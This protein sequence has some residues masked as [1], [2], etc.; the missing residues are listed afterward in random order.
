V[1]G[2]PDHW[3]ERFQQDQQVR[4]GLRV[5]AD[6]LE[7][8]EAERIAAI[9]AARRGGLSVRQ[10]AAA[11]RLSPARVHQPLHT[12]ASAT[13]VPA[14][15]AWAGGPTPAGTRSDAPLAATAALLRECSD[16]LERLDRGELVVVNLREPTEL[17][18]EYV[19][20][21]RAQ[22]RHVLQRMAR[23]LEG[24][25]AGSGVQREGPALTRWE[26]LADLVPQP[27]RLSPREERAQ[28]RRQLGLDP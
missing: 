9:A 8:A 18:T 15:I 1:V 20:V 14:A 13:G 22:V 27:P 11:V 28:L 12:S 10:I 24:L 26:R 3:R 19:A 2:A 6:R 25:A 16:W 5:V 21:D 23:E 17:Q 7:A 4:D